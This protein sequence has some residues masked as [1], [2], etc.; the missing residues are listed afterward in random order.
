MTDQRS[1]RTKLVRVAAL[2]FINVTLIALLEISSYSILKKFRPNYRYRPRPKVV[3]NQFHPYLGH[4]HPPDARLRTY[5]LHA[6]PTFIETDA[7]GNSKT[8]LV[9]EN[10]QIRLAVTGGSTMFG[11]GSS[12]NDTTV[13]S[14]VERI[15]NDKLGVRVDVVNLGKRA[16][17]SF[18]EMVLLDRYLASHKIDLVVAI[19]GFNDAD[20]ALNF[21][22]IEFGFLQPQV[23][24]QAVP[25]QRRAE[26]GEVFIVNWADKLRSISHTFDLFHALAAGRKEPPALNHEIKPPEDVDLLQNVPERVRLSI[27][28]Y[29]L[30]DRIARA[31]GAQFALFLQPT[32]RVRARGTFS[33]DD[34][35]KERTPEERRRVLYDN[36]YFEAIR[37]A[38]KEFVFYDISGVFPN[39]AAALYLNDRIHYTDGGAEL[40]AQEVV[41]RIQPLIDKK[42]HEKSGITTTQRH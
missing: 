13:P 34:V 29:S 36:A 17:A 25:L 39:D 9:V 2:V 6:K 10:P 18:Q 35:T 4:V 38:E 15:I 19:S 1:L 41:A 33:A 22:D 20:H 42:L 5:K 3:E 26:R 27:I 37:A 8:P 40:V 7:E 31:R 11:T 28:H 32:A 23:W 14:L 16:Y 24:E 12:N 21:P 30:M